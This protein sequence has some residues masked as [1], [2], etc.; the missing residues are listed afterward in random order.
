[1]ALLLMSERSSERLILE[2][3]LVPD[4]IPAYRLSMC[5][6]LIPFALYG[7]RL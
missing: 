1:M 3:K 5:T 6:A 7:R 4:A 2:E